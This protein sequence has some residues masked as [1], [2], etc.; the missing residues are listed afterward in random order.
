MPY[1]NHVSI[2][3]SQYEILQDT[4]SALSGSQMPLAVSSSAT[5]CD[6]RS[7]GTSRMM[8]EGRAS[9]RNTGKTR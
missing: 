8:L 2:N 3:V 4:S 6:A 7:I 1:T 5:A 9:A